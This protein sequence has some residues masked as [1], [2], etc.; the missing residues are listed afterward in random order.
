MAKLEIPQNTPQEQARLDAIRDAAL[1]KPGWIAGY[2]RVSTKEQ[3]LDRQTDAI[4]DYV[5]K[6]WGAEG[7]E[8]LEKGGMNEEKMSGARLSDRAVFTDIQAHLRAGDIVIAHSVDRVARNNGDFN[9][10]MEFFKAKGAAL[11]FVKHPDLNPSTP[12]GKLMLSMLSIF[13]EFERELIRERQRA[14]IA[15]AQRRG[16][17]K[18]R[19]LNTEQVTY[20]KEQAEAGVP[21]AQIARELGISRPSLYRYLDGTTLPSDAPNP[22]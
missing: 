1:K 10:I 15:A 8:A 21:K 19:A 5:S 14:G 11:I 7:V 16:K 9:Y 2:A 20:A 4:K 3:N 6:T 22:E 12:N 18:P 17:Y 13:A